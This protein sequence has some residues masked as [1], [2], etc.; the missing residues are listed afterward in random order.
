MSW[1][2]RADEVM[3]A[4]DTADARRLCGLTVS[5]AWAPAYL[6][7]MQHDL[8]AW[9]YRRRRSLGRLLHL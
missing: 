1:G 2:L 7:N 4:A 5:A 8:R 9:Q 6:W 3:I